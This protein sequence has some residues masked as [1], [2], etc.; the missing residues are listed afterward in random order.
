LLIGGL[1]VP[2]AV[3]VSGLGRPGGRSGKAPRAP[4]MPKTLKWV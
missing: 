4:E 1:S 2:V 3:I